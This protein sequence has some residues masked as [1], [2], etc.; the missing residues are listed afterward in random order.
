M[1]LKI[2][3]GL[4]LLVSLYDPI[5][6]GQ[7]CTAT[8]CVFG[9]ESACNASCYSVLPPK[10]VIYL[11]IGDMLEIRVVHQV[12]PTFQLAREDN[13]GM[14]D[15]VDDDDVCGGEESVCVLDNDAAS[16]K[17]NSFESTLARNYE[18]RFFY[19]FSDFC[20][21]PPNTPNTCLLYTSP[22]PRD[23]TR[24]RMPSSA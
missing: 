6:E 19:T 14:Y 16:F 23:R 9:C 8:P 15:E 17:I 21:T 12:L 18:Y 4:A 22:S 24:S 20:P 5:A 1:M 13:G 10:D 7:N 2:L 3:F 11:S